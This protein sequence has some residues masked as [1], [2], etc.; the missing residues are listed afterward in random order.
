[1][2]WLT[3]MC[4]DVVGL[5]PLLHTLRRHMCTHS[6]ADQHKRTPA[7][8]QAF[9]HDA[10]L[11]LQLGRCGHGCGVAQRCACLGPYRCC[12]AAQL[13]SLGILL[14]LC[15]SAHMAPRCLPRGESGALCLAAL[16]D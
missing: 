7:H 6:N 11:A 13:L 8:L 10:S 3:R 5:E 4:T 14:R 2:L 12:I 16:T 15:A 1:M 9:V